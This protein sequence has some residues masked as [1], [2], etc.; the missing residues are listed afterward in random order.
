MPHVTEELWSLLGFGKAS[1]QFAAPP[2]KIALDEVADLPGK[3]QLVSAIY[4]TAQAGRKLRAESNLPSNRKI[5]F[6][7][8]T[9]EKLIYEHI[10]TLVCLLNA[11]E[12]KLEP[13]YQ[14]PAGNPMAVTP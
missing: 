3:R 8:R 10:P 1:I 12:V 2:Q 7:L 4:Q 14:A 6:I 9:D 13:K 11:E 5:R